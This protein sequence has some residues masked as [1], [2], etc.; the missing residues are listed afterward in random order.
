MN[1]MSSIDFYKAIQIAA[2]ESPEQ[3]VYLLL[4]QAGLPGVYQELQKHSVPRVALF[5][6]TTEKSALAVAPVLIL[7][8]EHGMLIAKKRLYHWLS[9]YASDTFSTIFIISPLPIEA[10]KIRLSL[11]LEAELSEKRS[12]I[13]R[14][15]DS[16][17]L[18]ALTS[19]FDEVE[20]AA[21]FGLGSAWIY[22]DRSGQLETI[23]TV[24]NLDDKFVAPLK[25]HANQEFAFLEASEVDQVLDLLRTVIPRKMREFS[26]PEQFFLVKDL[27]S[28]AKFEGVESIL[29]YS[30]FCS[31]FLR[32]GSNV[33]DSPLWIDV[34][35]ELKSGAGDMTR[36]DDLIEDLFLE[37]V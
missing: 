22:P 4:D 37:L 5:E 3:N 27:V 25:L 19:I 21:F 17:I 34:M 18:M 28:K 36:L 20:R 33:L 16:R 10:M 30:I 14:Y 23:R 24:F 2:V 8:A 7:A 26:V 9:K 31:I 13:F 15:Y 11:R 12:A 32:G 35:K 6:D 1:N 29:G